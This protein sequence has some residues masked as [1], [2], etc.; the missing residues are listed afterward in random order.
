[1]PFRIATLQVNG[2]SEF[3]AEFELAWQQRDLPAFVLPPRSPKLNGQVE[4]SHRTHHEEF[5]QAIPEDWNV[6]HLHPQLRRWE[7]I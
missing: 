3:A 7:N 1:M 4:R 2:G 5:Y 6:A